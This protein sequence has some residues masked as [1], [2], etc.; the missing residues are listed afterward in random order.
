M[1]SVLDFSVSLCLCGE[2]CF[3]EAQSILV[4]PV[5]RS[6]LGRRFVLAGGLKNSFK[7]GG[8]A[9]RV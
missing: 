7:L 1:K 9:D 6:L 3:S 4:T 8:V 5:T 2:H